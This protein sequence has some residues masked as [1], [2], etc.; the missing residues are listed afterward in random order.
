MG[1]N[2]GKVEGRRKKMKGKC[3]NWVN[4][5]ISYAIFISV[6]REISKFRTAFG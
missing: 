3:Q 4:K 6:S 5:R 2:E 1:G